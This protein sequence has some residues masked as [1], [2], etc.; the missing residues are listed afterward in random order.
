MNPII[1]YLLKANGLLLFFWLFYRLF[2][3]KETFYTSIRWYFISAIILSL[4][5]PFFTYTKT[6][7]IEQE[8]VN[9]QTDLL[10]NIPFNPNIQQIEPSFWEK[11]DWQNILIYVIALISFFFIIRSIFHITKLFLNIKHLKSLNKTNIKITTNQKNVYSFYRWIVVPENKISSADFEMILAHENIHLNQKHTFDLILIELVSC[12]FWFNPLI[13]KFQKDINTNLEFIVDEKMIS[14]FEPVL[15]QKSLLNEQNSFSLTY[16]NAFNTNDLKKR[17][18]QLNTQK[19]RNMKELKFLVAAPVLASFFMLFQIETVAQIQTIEVENLNKSEEFTYV[20][21]E[22]FSKEDFQNL[23]KELKEKFNIDFDVKKVDYKNNLITAIDYTLR[24]KDLKIST[25]ETLSNK[26]IKPFMIVINLNNKPPFKVEKYY[27]KTQYAYTVDNEVDLDFFISENEWKDKSWIKKVSTNQKALYI[28][29]GKKV[30][31]TEVRSLDPDQIM[32]INVHRDEETK[33]KHDENADNI[34]I[35]KTKK[36]LKNADT[37]SFDAETLKT[38]RKVFDEVVKRYPIVVDHI[39]LTKKQLKQF[40]NSTIEHVRMD[41]DFAEKKQK[42]TVHLS[43]KPHIQVS[44]SNPEEIYLN[45]RKVT[46]NELRT[47]IASRNT[48]EDIYASE[49]KEVKGLHTLSFVN[50]DKKNISTTVINEKGVFVTGNPV[51][52]INTD[53]KQKTL[54]IVDGKEVSSEEINKT[55]PNSI[56]SITVLKDK[57]AIEKYGAKAKNGVLLITTKKDK[58]TSLQQKK[59]AL[60]ARELAVKERKELTEKQKE[61]IVQH[62]KEIEKHR[63]QLTTQKEKTVKEAEQSRKEIEKKRQELLAKRDE[64][65]KDTEQ[66]KKEIEKVRQ[67]RERLLKNEITEKSEKNSKEWDGLKEIFDSMK[68]SKKDLEDENAKI[69]H[70]SAKMTLKDGSVIEMSENY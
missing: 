58:E 3:R 42:T 10:Q 12:V 49:A 54:Y 67:E 40:D 24:N 68:Q 18:I 61:Q 11:I 45:G 46:K 8:Y 2:L 28:I 52:Y 48:G 16:I 43:T 64:I 56:E 9:Y 19:S 27:E 17:I 22:D 55:H 7:I 47:N 37:L 13:K 59:E 53:S 33:K 30:T 29:D 36:N 69:T 20:V 41:F 14:N 4:S 44:Y 39:P 23:S 21:K 15:Y 26:S 34:I 38:N 70:I 51:A 5:I 65:Q 32:S 25:S 63:Q 60:K 62:K 57:K 35:I 1:M 6:I 66:R 50:S 31:E